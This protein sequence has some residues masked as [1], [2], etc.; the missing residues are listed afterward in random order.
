M[1]VWMSFSNRVH[2]LHAAIANELGAF[3]F[4]PHVIE[5][6]AIFPDVLLNRVRAM[7]DGMVCS[8]HGRPPVGGWVGVGT[9][10][11]PNRHGLPPLS[12]AVAQ[13]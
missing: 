1:N 12:T 7:Q 8:F 11:L 3:P 10:I 5:F 9:P 13:P 4:M 2:R 6:R